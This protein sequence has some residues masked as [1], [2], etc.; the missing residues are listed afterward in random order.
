MVDRANK[1]QEYYKKNLFLSWLFNDA[2]STE[3]MQRRMTGGLTNV[4]Q[5]VE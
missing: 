3:T 1:Q 4:E 2:L 5:L